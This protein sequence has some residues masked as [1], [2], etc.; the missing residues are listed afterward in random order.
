MPE[1]RTTTRIAQHV[2]SSCQKAEIIWSVFCPN[3]DCVHRRVLLGPIVVASRTLR[4]KPG[5]NSNNSRVGLLPP[6]CLLMSYGMGLCAGSRMELHPNILRPRWLQAGTVTS[7]I[8][9]FAETEPQCTSLVRLL[10]GRW[11]RRSRAALR[12]SPD[13]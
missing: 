12:I 8:S 1:I 5:L 10:F 6:C 3:S 9:F 2:W 4:K 13:R 7:Y 11:S